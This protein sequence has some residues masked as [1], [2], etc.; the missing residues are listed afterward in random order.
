M[1]QS[2]LFMAEQ[3]D[4]GIK[5]KEIHHYAP[6]TTMNGG[7]VAFPSFHAI[8]AWYCLQLMRGWPIAYCLLWIINMLLILSC[9]L[10]GWHYPIDIIA[11]LV[12]ILLTHGIYQLLYKTHKLS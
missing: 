5:F 3:F 12:L 6:I 11:S 2:D 9:I 1:F 10:L 8:W 7:M 4:T